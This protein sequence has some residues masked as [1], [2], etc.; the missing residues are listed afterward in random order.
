MD[1]RGI[2]GWERDRWMIGKVV[3]NGS[4]MH[5]EGNGWKVSEW[6]NGWMSS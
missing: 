5:E 3:E 4:W 1:G 2:D 6:I